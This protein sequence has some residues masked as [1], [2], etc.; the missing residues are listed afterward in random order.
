MRVKSLYFL[1]P[2]R[3]GLVLMTMALLLTPLGSAVA[4]T[5][6]VERVAI[7]TPASRTNQAW[8]QQGV[9]NLSAVGK[10]LGIEVEV[11]ENAGYEDITPILQDLQDDGS[12][13]IVCHAS[14]YQ[15][16]CPEFA[17]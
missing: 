8:D 14:G 5:E 17:E 2:P 13:M 3:I 16:V 15:T 6:S 12:Q 10:D 9:D 4:E 7:I 11:A 1:S